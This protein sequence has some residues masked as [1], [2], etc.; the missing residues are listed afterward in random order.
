[1][2]IKLMKTIIIFTIS[3][4]LFTTVSAQFVAKVEVREPIQGL[5]NDKEVYTL[6]PMFGDQKEA[7]CPLSKEEITRRLDSAVTFLKDNP[8]FKDKGMVNI[9]INCKGEVVKCEMDNKTKDATLD[10]QIVAVF[11]ALGKWEAGRLNGKPVDSLR[12]YSFEIKKGQITV[13]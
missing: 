10:M 1:M 2:K 13:E 7:V 5:C 11:A 3:I 6:F 4:F 8:K 12:L 9:W